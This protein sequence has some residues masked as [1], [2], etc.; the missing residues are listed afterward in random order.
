MKRKQV[1]YDEAVERAMKSCNVTPGPDMTL[2]KA[3]HK[4]GIRRDDTRFNEKIAKAIFSEKVA[5]KFSK[6]G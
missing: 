1:K 4:L 5:A 3:K 2:A 6:K